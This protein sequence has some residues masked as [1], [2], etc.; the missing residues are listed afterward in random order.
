MGALT[1]A[2]SKM[3]GWKRAG[4]PRMRGAFTLPRQSVPFSSGQLC[5][6]TDFWLVDGYKCDSVGR[7]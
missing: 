6:L 3:H 4:M 5:G 1:E 2:R 7:G